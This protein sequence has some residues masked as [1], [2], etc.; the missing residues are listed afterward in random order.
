MVRRK[1]GSR[2]SGKAVIRVFCEGESEQA[3]TDF[4]KKRLKFRRNFIIYR[5][6]TKKIKI[7]RIRVKTGVSRKNMTCVFF[8]LQKASEKS[9]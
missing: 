3:Y 2:G 8:F 5:K 4:L 6:K 1:V 7:F 9:L